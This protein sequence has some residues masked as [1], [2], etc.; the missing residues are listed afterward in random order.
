MIWG[1]FGAGGTTPLVFIEGRQDAK[2]LH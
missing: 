1:G 2:K